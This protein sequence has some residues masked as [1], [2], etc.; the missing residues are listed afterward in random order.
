MKTGRGRHI[1]AYL[2]ILCLFLVVSMILGNGVLCFA[3]I[4]D[5]DSV[6]LDESFSEVPEVGDNTHTG[7]WIAIMVASGVAVLAAVIVFIV[8]LTRSKKQAEIETAEEDAPAEG[9]VSEQGIVQKKES[10][11][12]NDTK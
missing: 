10:D 8:L 11:E 12:A 6:F 3:A 7:R 4:G 1:T 5:S 2:R 9:T